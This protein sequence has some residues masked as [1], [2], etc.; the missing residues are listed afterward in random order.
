MQ[1]MQQSQLVSRDHQAQS[2]IAVTALKPQILL[3]LY[4]DV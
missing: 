1:D 4:V 3:Q 2:L